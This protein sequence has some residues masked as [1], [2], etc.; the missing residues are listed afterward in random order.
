MNIKMLHA[1]GCAMNAY[2][3][4]LR[5]QCLREQCKVRKPPRTGEEQAPQYQ[6]LPQGYPRSVQCP[7]TRQCNQDLISFSSH[8]ATA[9]PPPLICVIEEL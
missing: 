9:H 2:W 6:K 1:M 3:K 8:K 4:F 5:M 7:Q